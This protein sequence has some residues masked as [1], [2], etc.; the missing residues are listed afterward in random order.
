MSIRKRND[1][2]GYE[3]GSIGIDG[4]KSMDYSRRHAVDPWSHPGEKSEETAYGGEYSP[5]S[6]GDAA[7]RTSSKDT[8]FAWEGG[9]NGDTWG[10]DI[11]DLVNANSD[12]RGDSVNANS[13]P[14]KYGVNRK[15]EK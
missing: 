3:R 7:Q 4:K 12:V 11:M 8:Q 6:D 10:R 2:K 9:S 13:G 14:I 1:D 15:Q 5:N